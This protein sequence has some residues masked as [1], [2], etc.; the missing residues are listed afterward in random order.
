MRELPFLSRPR[1]T[2]SLYGQSSA[3]EASAEERGAGR[4]HDWGEGGKGLLRDA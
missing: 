2:R 4:E 1:P 3:K